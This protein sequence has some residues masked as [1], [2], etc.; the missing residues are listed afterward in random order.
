MLVIE[1]AV[2]SLWVVVY[3]AVQITVAFGARVV[4]APQL[5]GVALRRLSLIVN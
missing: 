2:M 4:A 1:T 3:V 5:N